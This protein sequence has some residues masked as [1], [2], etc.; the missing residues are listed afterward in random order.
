M[1]E[2]MLICILLEHNSRWSLTN[3]LSGFILLNTNEP[4]QYKKYLIIAYGTKYKIQNSSDH[5]QGVT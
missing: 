5:K 4:V 3:I 1:P 2:L